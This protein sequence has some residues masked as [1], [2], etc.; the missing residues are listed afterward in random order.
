MMDIQ[1]TVKPF[2]APE[3]SPYTDNGGTAVGIA[4]KDYVLIASETRL[5]TGYSIRTR[6]QSKI[7][8][9]TSKILLAATGC[10]CDALTF[11]KVIEARTKNYLYEH[12]RTIS[13]AACAQ[14]VSN[15]LYYKRFF[16]YYI[17]PLLAGLDENGKGLLY[18]YDPV[19]HCEQ[20]V[21]RAVGSSATLIQPVL[22]NKVGLKNVKGFLPEPAQ[23]SVEEALKLVKDVFVSAAE[24]DIYV[25]DFVIIHVITAAG[26]QTHKFPLRKD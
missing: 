20:H 4:G 7:F 10:F 12:N 19:G 17:S 21:Y 24:R 18:S 22:D 23:L 15:M 9:L 6:E 16:P 13:T 1:K 2:Q 3:F 25:G 11:A 26:T 14:L 8:P 5:S